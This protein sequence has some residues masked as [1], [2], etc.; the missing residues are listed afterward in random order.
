VA[1]SQSRLLWLSL[2]SK[3]IVEKSQS[4]QIQKI[5]LYAPT[6]ANPVLSWQQL[7]RKMLSYGL[8]L[9]CKD[10]HTTAVDKPSGMLSVPG[11]EIHITQDIQN[12]VQIQSMV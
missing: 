5:L 12:N 7:T 3:A 11:R 2:L 6:V 1:R 9:A 10:A 8:H 4:V